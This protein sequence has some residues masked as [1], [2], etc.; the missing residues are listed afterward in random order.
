MS[1][2]LV[3]DLP[4]RTSLGR[5]DF[6]VA[7]DNAG[8]MHQIDHWMDWPNGK[9]IL[10]GEEGSG[11]THL[12]HIWAADCA[13]QVLHAS[14][15]VTA[16]LEALSKSPVCIDDLH[17]I[18]GNASAEA[19]AFHLHNMLLH[20]NQPLLITGVGSWN[21]WGIG[22][23]DLQSRLGQSGV[24]ILQ[25]PDD[26]V[27]MAVLMKQ[28]TDKQMVV[29]PTTISYILRNCSRSFSDIHALVEAVDTEALQRKKPITR[30]LVADVMKKLLR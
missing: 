28:F 19:A 29:S 2:Q 16:E 30:V 27:L 13:G 20:E 22:L 6:F 11:K 7:N 14:D 17:L 4:R 3:F 21:H 26:A 23:P 9:L 18:A 12:A 15:L 10:C 8:L 1:E 25:S 5:E 24:V